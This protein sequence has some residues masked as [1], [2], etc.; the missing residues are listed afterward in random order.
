[1]D[2]KISGPSL[3]ASATQEARGLGCGAQEVGAYWAGGGY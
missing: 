1:M 3:G 2:I